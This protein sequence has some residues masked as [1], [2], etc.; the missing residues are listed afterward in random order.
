MWKRADEVSILLN[1]Q[2]QKY[3]LLIL[4]D[5][6]GFDSIIE[7]D[8]MQ[9]I[10]KEKEEHMEARKRNAIIGIVVAF[11]LLTSGILV[12]V[13]VRN[14]DVTR[15][16][17]VGDSMATTF[18][19]GTE[20]PDTVV[21]GLRVR[22]F[23]GRNR[24]RTI[25]ARDLQITP[26][27]ID[28]T[29]VGTFN[30]RISYG[31][32]IYTTVVITIREA[33]LTPTTWLVRYQAP[34]LLESFNA[35]RSARPGALRSEFI[36]REHIYQIGMDNEF[37]FI[38]RMT[39]I[40]HADL[41]AGN[42]WAATNTTVLTDVLQFQHNI[43]VSRFPG[44]ILSAT[45]VALTG[46]ALDDVVSIN[47]ET[48]HFQFTENAVGDKFR[49]TMYA[50]G[51]NIFASALPQY[52]THSIDVQVMH[53]W[54]A[55]SVADL[56]RLNN[57]A[58]SRWTWESY[59]TDLAALNDQTY[60]E[61]ITQNNNLRG[62]FLHTNITLSRANLPDRMFSTA[63]G[64]GQ[65]FL[66]NTV[67]IFDRYQ[68]EN[69]ERFNF[70]GNYFTVNANSTDLLIAPN[71]SAV[72]PTLLPHP[73]HNRTIQHDHPF[74]T[75][76][77][78]VFTFGG[79]GFG[80]MWYAAGTADPSDRIDPIQGPMHNNEV[81]RVQGP[82]TV[83]NIN[84]IGNSQRGDDLVH[85]GTARWGL[86]FLRITGQDTYVINTISHSFINNFNIHTTRF[87]Q[88]GFGTFNPVAG[89]GNTWGTNV[90][91][92]A[93][94][95]EHRT[96]LRDNRAYTAFSHH[97]LVSGGGHT[98]IDGGEFIDS[99]G[100]SLRA[101]QNSEAGRLHPDPAFIAA[102]GEDV[103]TPHLR[104]YVEIINNAVMESQISLNEDWFE[105]LVRTPG[106][107]QEAL[108][109]MRTVFQ[110]AL[111]AA[112]TM[113]DQLSVQ[114]GQGRRSFSSPTTIG[115]QTINQFNMATLVMEP[116]IDRWFP[117][118]T[119]SFNGHLVDMEDTTLRAAIPML[120]GAAPVAISGSSATVMSTDGT[121]S[122]SRAQPVGS[123]NML[124][125]AGALNGAPVGGGNTL[126]L[127]LP[128]SNP[129]DPT[130]DAARA[131]IID[132]VNQEFLTIFIRQGSGVM[133]AVMQV[134]H[135]AP[136]ITIGGIVI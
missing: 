93:Y 109:G 90:A 110:T 129:G 82:V 4:F 20:V 136:G 13:F 125:P 51:N 96:T 87:A 85:E 122:V 104:P 77:T 98:V 24:Y 116:D 68:P 15:I 108:N 99:G 83:R 8:S 26:R 135:N 59:F 106:M 74:N 30:M 58:R 5:M 78:S 101:L 27:S 10:K 132:F 79:S 34:T 117:E 54:N 60:L 86:N 47:Q 61:L 69:A 44:N 118:G 43:T 94:V 131:N 89:T 37:R 25:E 40:E 14:T 66:W 2:K 97:V 35:N 105:I 126:G 119:L 38:P 39:V 18:I 3:F 112:S 31:D 56:A 6:D 49:I 17:F 130:Y 111:H 50:S 7:H 57:S 36:D 133:A 22:G 80:N 11:V 62:M 41:M 88:A 29:N 55:Y 53:G 92:G 121:G 19:R 81:D 107:D 48:A 71:L 67:N 28:T 102:V 64:T 33:T 128:P 100:P 32:D 127:V 84:A 23:T 65:R 114:V 123:T 95:G 12:W 46:A 134:Q 21:E 72:N 45:P 91:Y 73:H 124:F 63:Q 76:S 9:T 1:S 42:L 75:A 52:Y 70:N 120:P 113:L 115:T 103:R 16:E